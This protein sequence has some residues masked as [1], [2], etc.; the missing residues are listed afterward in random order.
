M[1]RKHYICSLLLRVYLSF[2]VQLQMEDKYKVE[3]TLGQT[4]NYYGNFQR[5]L[6][7]KIKAPF[8]PLEDSFQPKV[9][10]GISELFEACAY[11]TCLMA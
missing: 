10:A 6:N 11:L 9:S 3:G 7:M 4:Q 1:L 8:V 5:L 2:N